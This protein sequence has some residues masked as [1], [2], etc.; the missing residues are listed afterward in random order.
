MQFIEIRWHSDQY[1]E[2]LELRDQLLRA[3]LGL[4][5]SDDQ[6][7]AESSQLHFGILDQRRLVACAVIVPVSEELAKLR[8]M[9]VAKSHQRQGVGSTLVQSIE[10][11]LAERGFKRIQLHARDTAVGFYQRLGYEKEGEP[12]IEVTIEHWKMSKKIP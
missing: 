9:V 8:Q 11:T 12:F 5:F 10:A 2:E 7:A 3:P 6:L 4:S 1:L